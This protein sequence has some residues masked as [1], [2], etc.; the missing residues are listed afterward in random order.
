MNWDLKC[1]IY[2]FTNFLCFIILASIA[3]FLIFHFIKSVVLIM[4][5]SVISII[6]AAY[7]EERI[8]SRYVNSIIAFFL[9]DE[10]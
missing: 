8:L 4:I 5:L 3:V 6:G 2:G 1:T 9:H 10:L 7:L